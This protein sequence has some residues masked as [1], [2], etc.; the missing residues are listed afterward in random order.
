[1]PPDPREQFSD[2]RFPTDGIDLSEGYAAQR[3]GTTRQGVNV[4]ACEPSTQRL[5]GGNRPGLSKYVG[6]A[7]P[8]QIQGLNPVVTASGAA[9]LADFEWTGPTISDP[10][11]PGLSTDWPPGQTSRIP[12]G[13]VI[14]E[15]GTLIQPNKKVPFQKAVVPQMI[16]F[17]QAHEGL[18]SGDSSS[19]T[20]DSPVTA[21]NLLLVVVQ[22]E[23]TL[24]SISGFTASVSDT[25]GNTW[26]QAGG[27]EGNGTDISVSLWYAIANSSGGCTVTATASG[28]SLVAL[29]MAEYS[30][31]SHTDT[32]DDVQGTGGFP[33]PGTMT[34]P[35]VGVQGSGELLFAAFAQTAISGSITA[36]T[37]FTGRGT[38]VNHGLLMEDVIGPS[39]D[40]AATATPGT[41][42]A[43]YGAIGASFKPAG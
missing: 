21:G 2:L 39:G 7:L 37:G 38:N 32:L 34:T 17:V 31:V 20:F 15:G 8:G 9:L 29:G 28:I 27:Y 4:R 11:T 5:R 43:A 30:G 13:Q 35:T 40:Q 3:K 10:S 42:S 14:P 26:T 6:S 12:T 19:Q 36:G 1:L 18:L 22:I 33:T 41:G 23:K 24:G 25:L 16:E